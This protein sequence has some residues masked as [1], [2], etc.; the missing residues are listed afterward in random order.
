MGAYD[1]VRKEQ[2]D[3]HHLPILINGVHERFLFHKE[4]QARDQVEKGREKTRLI[5]DMF[6]NAITTLSHII[7]NTLS[8]LSLNIEE[9]SKDLLPAV[10]DEE[11][12]RFKKVCDEMSHQYSLLSQGV[13]SLLMLAQAFR[14]GLI[15]TKEAREVEEIMRN[16]I[17]S[18]EEEHKK[19]QNDESEHP[20]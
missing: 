3:R 14:E 20:R 19:V 17:S 13:R 11:K 7:N 6:Y 15:G 8:L 18:L 16:S 12:E 4:K 2:F 10:K 1:Y 5:L 9:Q